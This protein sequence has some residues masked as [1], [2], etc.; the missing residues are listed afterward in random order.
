M[1]INKSG[2][3]KLTTNQTTNLQ[4]GERDVAVPVWFCCAKCNVQQ[5]AE[6]LR[7]NRL[8]YQMCAAATQPTAREAGR[9]DRRHVQIFKS[10]HDR[11]PAR[12]PLKC[13]ASS[14]HLAEPLI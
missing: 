5:I 14:L 4:T 7:G 13:T 11:K 6:S 8:N 10:A 9:S 1:E 3:L 2:S 12:V